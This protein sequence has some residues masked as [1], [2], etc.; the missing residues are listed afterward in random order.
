MKITANLWAFQNT[1]SHMRRYTHMM[2]FAKKLYDVQSHGL[3][4]DKINFEF[5][6]RRTH[7]LLRLLS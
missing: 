1:R 3:I 5:R 6:V 2:R 7:G 4:K